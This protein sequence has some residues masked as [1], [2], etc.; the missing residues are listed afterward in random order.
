MENESDRK[1][2]NGQE[3]LAELVKTRRVLVL[4]G[5]GGVGKTTTSAALALAGAQ[6]GRRVLVLTIDPA[7][8]LAQAMGI[9]PDSPAPTPVPRDRLDACGVSSQGSLDAWMLDPRVIFEGMVRRLAEPER[10]EQILA[11][12]LFRHLTDLVAGMQ[13]Y[14]AAEA[15]YTFAEERRY[16][17][18]VLDTPPSRNALE[19]LDAPGRVARFLDDGVVN[20]FLPKSGGGILRRAGRLV[21]GVFSRVFGEAFAAELQTFLQAFSGMFGAMREH[22]EGLNALL[23]SDDAA[24]LLVTSTE[25]EALNE[26][27]FFRDEIARRG[28]PLAGFILNRSWARYDALSHPD[29]ISLDD[30]DDATRAGIEKFKQLA[31]LERAQAQTDRALLERLQLL[32]D[33]R[34]AVAAPHL[35]EAVEDLRGLVELAK[36]LVHSAGADDEP[37]EPPHAPRVGSH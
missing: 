11:N 15:L 5:A 19:F 31:N 18:I 30:I 16:D 35:G 4:C 12:R 2:T 37:V 7:K 8:R 17:L 21:S 13:E 36:G 32:A 22:T 10:A 6:A 9:P 14:M 24:F 20:L 3:N 25:E 33:A 28:L 29:S 1:A 23:A 34:L 26:S 27:L